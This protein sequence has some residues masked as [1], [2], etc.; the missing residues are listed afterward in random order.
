MV[1]KKTYLNIL[2][3]KAPQLVKLNLILFAA[4]ISL[5]AFPMQNGTKWIYWHLYKSF[6][7]Y[8]DIYPY[9]ADSI[10][11]DSI[12]HGEV[13]K[14]VIRTNVSTFS[15]Y[16]GIY[17]MRENGDTVFVFDSSSN[18]DKIL[19]N[20]AL[21]ANDTTK[22]HFLDLFSVAINPKNEYVNYGLTMTDS[23]ISIE[24][25]NYEPRRI[26]KW[27]NGIGQIDDIYPNPEG[28]ENDGSLFECM[29]NSDI[30]YSNFDLSAIHNMPKSNLREI[31]ISL[32]RLNKGI[33]LNFSSQEKNCS[34]L[35]VFNLE[36]RIILTKQLKP[37]QKKQFVDNLPKGMLIFSIH[38]SGNDV[39][40][41]KYL[42]Y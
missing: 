8:S 20:F 5:F 12:I 16:S 22:Y 32:K 26:I 23:I 37:D 30:L 38:S 41:I 13:Y 15:S 19:F 3:K 24:T 27:K 25:T 36:G 33:V 39:Q 18:H 35:K 4:C 29:T 42:N 21:K 6:S 34:F 17:C 7:N 9:F 2:K 11:G 1:H 31:S 28:Y 14:K 40:R 10:A